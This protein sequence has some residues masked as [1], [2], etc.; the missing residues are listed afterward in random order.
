MPVTET[1]NLTG[2]RDTLARIGAPV[3]DFT[4]L[5]NTV[6]V[7]LVATSKRSIMEGRSPGGT[8]FA[9]W[10]A[11]TAKRRKGGKILYDRGLM[12][13]AYQA[14]PSGPTS[15]IWGNA[16]QYFRYQ[17]TGTRRMPARVTVEASPSVLDRIA[18][19]A[20]DYAIKQLKER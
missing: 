20:A 2:L 5:L 15:V 12:L 8:P 1:V 3:K 10:A 13:A 4:P 19:M 14:Q 6:R 7:Y 16:I 18:A 11:S 17:Q 9:P